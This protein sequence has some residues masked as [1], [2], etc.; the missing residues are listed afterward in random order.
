MS[1]SF[2]CYSYIGYVN[3]YPKSKT[4]SLK[5]PHLQ[6]LIQTSQFHMGVWY[7]LRKNK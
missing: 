6:L 2:S 4:L 7:K 5:Y 3:G 1:Y